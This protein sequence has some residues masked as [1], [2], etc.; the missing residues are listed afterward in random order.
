MTVYI[1]GIGEVTASESV[2]NSIAIVFGEARENYERLSLSSLA[3]EADKARSSI[4]VE[5]A[6]VGYYDSVK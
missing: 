1:D 6:K 5:L 3:D 2:L 4:H